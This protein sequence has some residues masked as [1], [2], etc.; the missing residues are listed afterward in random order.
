MY[1]CMYY[2]YIQVCMYLYVYI[3]MLEKAD[4]YIIIYIDEIISNH[5]YLH[6]YIYTYVKFIYTCIYMYILTRRS[7]LIKGREI[8]LILM[9]I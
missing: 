9:P 7:K 1:V 8:E 6:I 5:T 4:P 2:T 3:H